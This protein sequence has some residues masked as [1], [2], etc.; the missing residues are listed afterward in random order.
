MDYII[1]EESL[2]IPQPSTV[3]GQGAQGTVLAANLINTDG[4]STRVAIKSIPDIFQQLEVSALKG[5]VATLSKLRHPNIVKFYGVTLAKSGSP[6]YLVMERLE[7]SLDRKILELDWPKRLQIAM[8][9]VSGVA[10]IHANK[11]LHRDLKSANILL[12]ENLQAKVC[13]F[14]LARMR[15]SILSGTH[16]FLGTVAYM[17]PELVTNGSAAK[18]SSD[19]Y[20]LGVLFSEIASCIGPYGET[21][22]L[23]YSRM[24]YYWTTG[25]RPDMSSWPCPPLFK[26]LVKSL[27]KSEPAD[28]WTAVQ[29]ADYL[30]DHF[31][32]LNQYVPTVPDSKAKTLY[33]EMAATKEQ[34]HGYLAEECI[35]AGEPWESEFLLGLRRS[36][37]VV[38]LISETAVE[39]FKFAHKIPDNFLLEWETALELREARQ[40]FL[41]PVF[42]GDSLYASHVIRPK[43][44][45]ASKFPEEYPCHPQSPKKRT[46]RDIING[47]QALE[48]PNLV[49]D[50]QLKSFVRD[51]QVSLK[52]Q[53]IRDSNRCSAIAKRSF[54]AG[55]YP[56]AV[57]WAQKGYQLTA[58]AA[59]LYV[60]S[61]CYKQGLGGLPKDPALTKKYL[62]L[63]AEQGDYDALEE[64]SI[65]QGSAI[66]SN[67]PVSGTSRS[68]AASGSLPA[69][70]TSTFV[71][72]VQSSEQQSKVDSDPK[73]YVDPG[74]S[75]DPNRKVTPRW[76]L[77]WIVAV[78]VLVVAIVGAVLGTQLNHSG[79]SMAQSTYSTSP[80]VSSATSTNTSNANG[81]T[82][83]GTSGGGSSSGGSSGGGTSSGGSSSAGSSS[84]GGSSGG[85]SG[86]G[87]SAAV[88]SPT[89]G[90][91]AL[92]NTIVFGAQGIFGVAISSNNQVFLANYNGTINQ[93]DTSGNFVYSWRDTGNGISPYSASAYGGYLFIADYNSVKQYDV[94]SRAVD[95]TIS[96]A[97][98]YIVMATSS[99]I[100]AGGNNGY[101][102]LYNYNGA[103]LRQYTGLHDQ[104]AS[105]FVTSSYVFVGT[106]NNDPYIRQYDI[107]TGNLVQTYT[108]HSLIVRGLYVVNG[109]VYSGSSDGTVRTWDTAT[110]KQINIAS[111]PTGVVGLCGYGNRIF[112]AGGDG[113]GRQYDTAGNLV[114]TYKTNQGDSIRGCG[115][116]NNYVWFASGG[117][118]GTFQFN[119]YV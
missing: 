83:G 23:A 2:E 64:R 5:E 93:Y 58:N 75:F 105:I 27:W 77:I 108:G 90:P 51:L 48:G 13:D 111:E 71:A 62:D 115:A 56:E 80:A 29:V 34:Q 85:V 88:S 6:S 59:A 54:T 43:P 96:G 55:E 46:I 72:T 16:G 53:I 19:M 68:T 112:S 65:L 84:G 89:P 11:V 118:V 70:E 32:E 104:V 66:T 73:Q 79:T 52:P 60:L 69:S 86:G 100:F 25:K 35:P 91:G 3:L 113:S 44:I 7:S 97:T 47:V 116:N 74:V 39:Q 38:I 110:G 114:Y 10:Y 107:S 1:P 67:A 49:V 41:L 76:R 98:Y 22:P 117:S 15:D 95:L 87:P 26:D 94:A 81:S 21:P 109:L 12:D 45:D 24:Q 31:S 78:T 57:Y 40:S 119:L 4:T 101:V 18:E 103:T 42:I 20:S 17:A 36:R 82:N 30:K 14:G 106:G 28:R 92:V 63:A 8:D 50:S 61:Q 99:G 9:I 33:L 37:M 102:A